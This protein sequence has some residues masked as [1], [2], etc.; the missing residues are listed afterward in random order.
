MV[1]I[2]TSKQIRKELEK[3]DVYEIKPGI[4]RYLESGRIAFIR[5]GKA[6]EFK[7]LKKEK[8]I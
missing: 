7:R 4:F 3:G 1:K 6:K 5:K 8:Y 2:L